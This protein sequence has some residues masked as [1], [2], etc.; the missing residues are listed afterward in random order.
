[1]LEE[2]WRVLIGVSREFTNLTWHAFGIC[3][4]P[5][6]IEAQS[7]IF[8][9]AHEKTQKKKQLLEE[10]T[11]KFEHWVATKKRKTRSSVLTQEVQPEEVEYK[12][13][14]EE[15]ERQIALLQ[16][17]EDFIQKELDISEKLIQDIQKEAN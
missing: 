11:Q 14:K 6:M 2:K 7:I 15:L 1:M 8:S 9:E 5:F 4:L 17:K 12:H 13:D 10:R 3:I 16:E